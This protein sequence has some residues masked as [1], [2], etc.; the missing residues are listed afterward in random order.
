MAP[1]SRLA[2][3]ALACSA[4][5]VNSAPVLAPPNVTGPPAAFANAN[6]ATT[7]PLHKRASAA[8]ITT[9]CTAPGT[10]AITFDDGPYEYTSKLLDILK[11]KNVKATFFV[12]GNNYAKIEDFATVVKRAYTDGHQ[13]ASHTWDH[14][15]L[16]KLSSS[17][18]T[19]EM[20]MLDAAL[21]KILGVRPVFM[22][23]PYGSTSSTALKVL[24]NLGYKVITWDVDTEDWQHPTNVNASFVHYTNTLG[25]SGENKKPGHIFLEHDVN[26]D[27]AL[28]LAPKAI[29][30]AL[31]KGF[32]VVTV[33][34]CLGVA[35]KN[36]YR[37]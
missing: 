29:D 10:V 14:A 19:S 31:S 21:K 28:L 32:K 22:R 8:T 18:V 7:T 30:Y 33:G 15:D 26:H 9:H 5:F 37:A 2:L 36:W 17:K 25:K 27:T 11:A 35:Q 13:V 4:A 16:A 34:T 1:F 12:N 23:P 3:I 24:G 6:E 20:T